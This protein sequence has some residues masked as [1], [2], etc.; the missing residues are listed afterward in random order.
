MLAGWPV[1]RRG[2]ESGQVTG[3]RDHKL[4]V[5]KGLGQWPLVATRFPKWPG[6]QPSL[7][8]PKEDTLIFLTLAPSRRGAAASVS[9][10]IMGVSL[11][12]SVVRTTKNLTLALPALPRLPLLRGQAIPL[13]R[14]RLGKQKKPMKMDPTEE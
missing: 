12:V 6:G 3:W 4:C 5:C 1:P 8:K 13:P 11:S 14:G 7:M 10:V 9:G 2:R